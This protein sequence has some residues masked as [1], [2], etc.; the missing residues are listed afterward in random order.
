MGKA[1][2]LIL[3]HMSEGAVCAYALALQCGVYVCVVD[4]VIPYSCLP[5]GAMGHDF[6]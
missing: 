5:G 1:Q 2:G 4:P 3:L 6:I